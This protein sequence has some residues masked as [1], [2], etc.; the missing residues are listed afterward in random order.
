MQRQ[1]TKAPEYL[2]GDIYEKEYGECE[3]DDQA[4]EPMQVDRTRDQIYLSGAPSENGKA[5]LEIPAKTNNDVDMEANE[6]QED[7]KKR[8]HE[9]ERGSASADSIVGQLMQMME[10]QADTKDK[11]IAALTE[12]IKQLQ[13]QIQELTR[14]MNQSAEDSE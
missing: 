13:Q 9:K 3:D 6:Q 2:L 11:Q 4:L 1:Q 12:T 8:K 14:A 10:K 7:G 5:K